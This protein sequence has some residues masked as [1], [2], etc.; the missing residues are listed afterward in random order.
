M[1][2]DTYCRTAYVALRRGVKAP[3]MFAKKMALGLWYVEA[4]DG[5]VTTV[6]SDVHCANCAKVTAIGK[7][8]EKKG[9]GIDER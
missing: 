1:K 4:K 7:W 5:S 3:V 9:I 8:M 6:V 2:Q